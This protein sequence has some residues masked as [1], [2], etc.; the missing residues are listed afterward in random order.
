MC[1]RDRFGYIE[2]NGQSNLAVPLGRFVVPTAR[3]PNLAC[4]NDIEI[5]RRRVARD[6]RGD[7]APAR[8]RH[9][10]HRLSDALFAVTLH[11]AEFSRWQQLL[12]S[13]GAI[14]QLQRQGT[15]LRAGPVPRLRPEWFAAADD[16]S[17][18]LRLAFAM[19][20]QCLAGT[21][22]GSRAPAAVRRHWLPLDAKNPSRFATSND[23]LDLRPEV[24]MHGLR[25]EDDAIALV[26]RA[27]VEARQRGERGFPLRCRAGADASASDLAALVA[28]RVDLDRTLALARPLMAL[29]TRADARGSLRRTPASQEYP[30]DA[31]LAI[32]LA[33]FPWP[34]DE[35]ARVGAE[36]R[37]VER[38]AAG[39]AGTAVELALRRLTLIGVTPTVRVA[40]VSPPL[41]RLWAAAL[42]FPIS[43]RTAELFLKRL[44]KDLERNAS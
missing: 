10:W 39:D 6:S 24:V 17:S 16:G 35:R 1:I 41:A 7:N 23:R 34:D 19:A 42:A 37:I 3:V 32:R 21:R 36:L 33:L 12:V 44:G 4:L 14:E 27:M 29:D 30:D 13:L 40:C 22:L 43:L 11:P 38:L 31:W 5:W 20:R 25:G 15:A 8:A 2:R 28:G 26:R 18:E 9:A